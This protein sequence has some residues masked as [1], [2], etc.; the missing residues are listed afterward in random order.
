MSPGISSTRLETI[1]DARAFVSDKCPPVAGRLYG[2]TRG[3]TTGGLKNRLLVMRAPRKHFEIGRFLHLKS[4][5][6]NLKMDSAHPCG[7]VGPI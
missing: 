1:Y 2:W 4:E 7:A 3:D 5:I 6:R